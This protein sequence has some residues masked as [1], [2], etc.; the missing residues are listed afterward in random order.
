[1][2]VYSHVKP[3]R[4]ISPPPPLPQH[5]Q[6]KPYR[7][8]EP[9]PSIC[10]ASPKSSTRNAS[11]NSSTHNPLSKSS[12][13]NPS[14]EPS[15]SVPPLRIANILI[16]PNLTLIDM[17]PSSFNPHEELDDD[18]DDEDDIIYPEGVTE[19]RPYKIV[20]RYRRAI[21]ETTDFR[22]KPLVS[23]DS[24]ETL[25]LGLEHF[26]QQHNCSLILTSEDQQF[27][28]SIYQ[29]AA[30]VADL[31]SIHLL[32]T[33]ALLTA[34]FQFEIDLDYDRE[35]I[36]SEENIQKFVEDFCEAICKVLSC[37]NGNVRVF[38]INKLA[39]EVGKSQINF[40]LT[41]PEQK[42]TE[43][44]AH[45]LKIYARSGFGTDTILQHVK[46]GEYE[47]LWKTSGLPEKLTRGSYPYYLPLGWYRY[48]LKVLDKYGNDNAWIGQVD[49]EGEWPVAFYGTHSGAVSSIL[50]HGLLPNAVKTDTMKQEAITQIGEEA[51]QPGFYVTTHCEGGSYPQYTTPFT[52]TT[53]PNKSEQF[54]LVF[55]CRVQPGKFT[56]HT[57]PVS[58]GE[59]W[60]IIDP[61]AIRPY[62]ILVKKEVSTK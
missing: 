47:C 40:G 12:T 14:P 33:D 15:S 34:N 43:Q 19:L 16:E 62:G 57:S 32:A 49:A 48:A 51:N 10:D 50:Q 26:A 52:V 8:P 35:I 9:L 39:D 18:D 31:G 59:V 61:T 23:E 29:A 2:K 11:P 5:Q 30:G 53:F 38:S 46:P 60:R 1:M 22:L 42:R 28:Q 20:A 44:L 56:I 3:T 21:G 45:D 4:N 13:R 58:V 37:E 7:P 6:S 41:T 17:V 27:D 24:T 54:S 36:Q 25:V 55:Q